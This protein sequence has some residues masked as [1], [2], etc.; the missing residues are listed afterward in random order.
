MNRQDCRLRTVW[1]DRLGLS[2][3]K[4]LV[5]LHGGT[6]HSK[7]QEGKGSRFVFSIPVHSEIVES[8]GPVRLQAHDAQP[9]PLDIGE[10]GD[11]RILIVDDEQVN[12]QVLVNHLSQEG[13]VI[14]T[15][16]G[17]VEA[18]ELIEKARE[19]GSPF[20]LLILDVMMPG[21]TG[22]DVCRTLRT[23]SRLDLPILLLTVRNQ[24][25]DVLAG[26]AAGA[27]DYLVK[28]FNRQELMSRVGT[29]LDL[30]GTAQDLK[31]A[32]AKLEEYSH[33]LEKKVQ[34]RTHDLEEAKKAAEA[35]NRSKS[36]FLAVMSHEIRTSLVAEDFAI[37]RLLMLTQLKKLGLKADEAKNG[38]EVVQAAANKAYALIFMDCQMPEMDGY[39]AAQAIRRQEA[40]QGRRTPIVATS[41]SISSGEK[42]KCLAAG[43]DDFLSKPMGLQDVYE[44][45]IKWL[46]AP[47]SKECLE[48]EKQLLPELS[49]IDAAKRD[50]V[51]ELLD[52]D[53]QLLVKALEI[54]LRDTQGKLKALKLAAG[55]GDCPAVQLQAHGMK[56]SSAFLGITAMAELC[57]SLE[58]AAAAGTLWRRD[59]GI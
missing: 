2:I 39:A 26:F 3:T 19:A 41:A 38:Q 36:D 58:E 55:R 32:L 52:W 21:M 33:S 11:Y 54:Y 53:R 51:L 4:R 43:M 15:A 44:A 49:F 1:E 12:R 59:T 50:E 45:L 18:L 25:E 10:P 9:L 47:T 28:P 22:Y 20:H 42:D 29:I 30:K 14:T 8:P 57:R 31:N 23:T 6:I 37:N 7:S 34:D 13:Y 40:L 17:G 46:P 56:S 24:A 27:N 48:V 5:E 16:A 35:A